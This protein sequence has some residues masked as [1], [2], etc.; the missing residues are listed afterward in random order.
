VLTTRKS[1]LPVF[2]I[3]TFA[4]TTIGCGGGGDGPKLYPV[5]GKVTFNG[6]PVKE[7]RVLFR[8]QGAGGRSYSAAIT[9]GTYN[10]KSEAG[11]AAVEITAS[12]IIPGKFD[13]SNGTPEPVGEM[14][15]PKMYNSA[16]TLKAEVKPESNTIPFDLTGKK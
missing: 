15:I 2:G 3:L 14:Y 9:D 16:T 8:M 6:E 4:L 7:G 5:T 1:L 11:S 13:K 10:L 12:R